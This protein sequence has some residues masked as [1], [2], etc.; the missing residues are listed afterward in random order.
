MKSKGQWLQ[1][2]TECIDNYRCEADE[3]AAARRDEHGSAVISMEARARVVNCENIHELRIVLRLLRVLSRSLRGRRWHQAIAKGNRVT[4][5]LVRIAVGIK[6]LDVLWLNVVR[7][8]NH[9]PKKSHQSHLVSENTDV[10][11]S[12]STL[13]K[14]PSNSKDQF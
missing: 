12:L 9:L 3:Y 8:M 5:R 2:Y 6:N 1:K 7:L 14:A 11:S 4:D 10:S 13:S